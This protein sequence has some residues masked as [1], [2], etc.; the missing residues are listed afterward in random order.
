MFFEVYVSKSLMHFVPFLAQLSLMLLFVK[1][2]I[3]L[4]ISFLEENRHKGRAG[5]GQYGQLDS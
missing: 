2:G 1:C 4:K 5:H 3:I